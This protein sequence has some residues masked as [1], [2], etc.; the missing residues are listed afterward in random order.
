MLE[1]GWN[2]EPF[3]LVEKEGK[4]FG[5][6]ST[7]DKGPVLGWLNVIETMQG[8]GIDMPIN[9]KFVFEGM[10]ESGSE[11]LDECL[12]K[13]KSFLSDVDFVCI[14]DNYWLGKQ[15]PCITYGLRGLSPF[16]LEITAP[17]QDLHSGLYGGTIHEPMNDLCWLLSQLSDSKGTILVKGIDK[18]VAKLTEEERSLYAKIDFD[19]EGLKTDI[20]VEK[21]TSDDPKE[22]LMRRWRQPSLSIHGIEGAFSGKGLKTVIP[23]KVI[24]K[25]SIRIVPHMTPEEVDKAVVAHVTEVWKSRASPNKMNIL[26]MGGSSLAWLGDFKHPHFQAGVKA[27]KKVYGVEPDFTREGGSIPVALTFQ[28]M[29]KNVM[30]LPMGA[31]D[32][33]AHS[34]NE[35]LNVSNYVNGMKVFAAYILECAKI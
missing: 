20:G 27:I 4:L 15:K 18:M 34:Q 13:Y 28:N 17:N 12:E 35:K 1:D 29:G 8:L 26:P 6:G 31:S 5:R 25:F 16:T 21:L 7:D 32:D 24:G 33:M 2:T 9:M 30:L 3:K 11:G 14:S 23:S 19:L 22:I 10:E